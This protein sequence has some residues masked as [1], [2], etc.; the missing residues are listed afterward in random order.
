[1]KISI[2][3]C[4]KKNLSLLTT[5]SETIEL[6]QRMHSWI[7]FNLKM[8]GKLVRSQLNTQ[9]LSYNHFCGEKLRKI[10][11]QVWCHTCMRA[12]NRQ[13][14]FTARGTR[15]AFSFS[16]NVSCSITRV[17]RWNTDCWTT[18]TE[19]LNNR[20]TSSNLMRAVNRQPCL[21][22][23]MTRRAPSSARFSLP[24]CDIPDI[25][26]GMKILE[27][28]NLHRFL[29]SVSKAFLLTPIHAKTLLIYRR[30]L[31]EAPWQFLRKFK[32]SW[33]SRLFRDHKKTH[34]AT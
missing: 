1:M 22:R 7:A 20:K 13:P 25:P 17:L 14:M 34:P 23:G 8:I 10:L 26:E 30:S 27:I 3:W 28:Y 33:K 5:F 9:I 21:P 4:H 32:I 18:T 6:T 24:A 15:R 12:V 29:F 19:Q 2:F 11:G 31:Q 16:V